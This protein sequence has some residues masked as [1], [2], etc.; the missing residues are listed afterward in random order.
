ML[1]IYLQKYKISMYCVENTKPTKK[2]FAIFFFKGLPNQILILL[3]PPFNKIK[4]KYS[5]EFMNL[6]GNISSMVVLISLR[7][8]RTFLIEIPIYYIFLDKILVFCPIYQP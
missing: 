4:T 1:I 6:I 3:N 2:M 8:Y 5:P 7:F